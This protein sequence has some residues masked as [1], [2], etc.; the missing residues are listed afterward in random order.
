MKYR[1]TKVNVFRRVII[2]LIL[3]VCVILVDSKPAAA[4]NANDYFNYNYSVSIDKTEVQEGETF[5][6]SVTAA[7]VCIQDL[8][9]TFTEATFTGRIIAQN[10]ENGASIILYPQYVT[11]V[12][13]FPSKQGDAAQDSQSIILQF[14]E[15]TEPG[16]YS[17]IGELIRARAKFLFIWVDITNYLPAA[18]R[19]K[20]A[21]SVT[22]L[23][24]DV[25]PPP[26]DESPAELIPSDSEP[27]MT[28]ISSYI[29]TDGTFLNTIIT[30]SIDG[31]CN[32][33]IGVGTRGH[34]QSKTRLTEIYML[35]MQSP[36]DPP[37]NAHIVG[38][39]Y[40]LLPEGAT[41][42]PSANLTIEYTDSELPQ[43]FN[44]TD[45]VISMW[46][47]ASGLWTELPSV[48]DSTLKTVTAPVSHFTAFAILAYDRQPADFTVSELSINPGKVETGG[49]VVVS[50]LVTNSGSLGGS[51]EVV[52]KI[53]SEV[54]DTR[55][56]TLEGGA[57]EQI[58]FKV[59]RDTAGTYSVDLN[60][61]SGEFVVYSPAGFTVSE[62]S[63]NPDEAVTGGEVV[64]SALV[65]NSGSLGGSYEVVLKIDSKVEETRQI[66]L[67]GGAEEQ[68]TF[69]VSRDTAGTY[70][71]D[72]NGQS[73][74]FTIVEE[75]DQ[76]WSL[77]W[78][79]IVAIAAG[80]VV[81]GFLLY[82]IIRRR[83]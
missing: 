40:N 76:V 31:K 35:D 51:Y 60:G 38:G 47:K 62:L 16:T 2:A 46:D 56:V 27:G 52:L 19:S 9:L 30:Q 58:I 17:I 23:P 11:I 81:V 32:L 49:E 77:S 14:P 57:E 33:T 36:P 21:G 41:F 67:E 25:T 37:V 1:T 5:Q 10:L 70:S 6:V 50:A 3:A 74:A 20:S 54:E 28:D 65:T 7:A 15:G 53:D 22:L 64:I 29:G 72:L 78:W 80:T 4:L 83:S 13:P 59:S 61:L 69:K 68:I 24:E 39:V 44:E 48:V 26:E 12:K 63:I 75:P 66:T 34:N 79:L 43:D 45:L 82:L 55:Q 8:P 18:E 42:V 71:V 73:G